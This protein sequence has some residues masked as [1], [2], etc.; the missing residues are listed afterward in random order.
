MRRKFILAAWVVFCIWALGSLIVECGFQR[1]DELPSPERISFFRRADIAFA[2]VYIMVFLILLLTSR[3]K[4]N[5]IRRSRIDTLLVVVLVVA[6][7]V[8]GG[9]VPR[10]FMFVFKLLVGVVC[11]IRLF[12]A[13]IRFLN[14]TTPL[15]IVFSFL[16]IIGLGFFLLMLPAATVSGYI[17]P[18]DALFTATSATCVTGLVVVDTGSYFSPFGEVI[19]LGLVQIGGLGLMTLVAFFSATMGAGLSSRTEGVV[20]E[21]LDLRI[22]ISL[23]SIIKFVVSSTFVLE[24]LGALGIF[25]TFPFEQCQSFGE[26]LYF[27]VFHSIS[28]FCNAGF[29]LL[30]DSMVRVRSNLGLNAVMIGLI[31]IGGFGFVVN[32]AIWKKLTSFLRRRGAGVREPYQRFGVQV[33]LVLFTSVILTVAGMGIIYFGELNRSFQGFIPKERVLAALFQSVSARTAGFNTVDIGGLSVP[34]LLALIGLM[35]IGASPGS[36]GGGVKTTTFSVFILAIVTRL[37]N[38]E[39]VEVYGRTIPE[40]LIS[41]ALIILVFAMVLIFVFTALV[42]LFGL[43]D[44]KLAGDF[45]LREKLD[46]DLYLRT[47]FEVVSAFGTVGFSTGITPYLSTGSKILIILMMLIGRIGP[48]TILLAMGRQAKKKKYS[49]PEESIMIG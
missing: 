33:R 13:S 4:L 5:F 30:P 44:E 22:P 15:I 27:S 18:V 17:R 21:S 41:N 10:Y 19:I 1:Y 35:F 14:L 34:V 40:R 43:D 20:L 38:R 3:G 39:N 45:A 2:A 37:R 6:M 26:R 48:F 23:F 28:A 8:S 47:V 46:K 29:S 11:L 31:V 42:F 9:D 12:M 7:L 49:Y 16:V 24:A 32:L 25:Y 36:T